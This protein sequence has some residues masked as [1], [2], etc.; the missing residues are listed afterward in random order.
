M[1]LNDSAW[2][3]VDT[4]RWTVAERS[5]VVKEQTHG[6]FRLAA[7]NPCFELWLLLHFRDAWP[8][9]GGENLST[10]LGGS[11]CFGNYFKNSYPVEMLGSRNQEAIKRA[12]RS[13]DQNHSVWPSPGSTRV[14]HAVQ[15]ILEPQ[16]S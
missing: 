1:R 16:S 12:A 5:V 6:D 9:V 11:D 10:L 7:S 3:V 4:D 13:D 8:T 15:A 14:H 2:L